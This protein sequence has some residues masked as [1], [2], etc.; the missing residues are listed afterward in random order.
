MPQF[1]P[2]NQIRQEFIDFF[3]QRAR[4]SF[5]PSSA[6]VPHD[7]PTLLFANAGM[8]QFK[9]LFLGNVAPG[10]PLAG[11]KRAVNSQK[12]I[13]AGG[14]HNDL[15][16]VGKDG[17]HHTF[18]EMLGNWSF[19]DYFKEESIQW[20]WEL[21]TQIWG[22][23][24]D[25]LYATYF[26]GSKE[27]GIEPDREAYEIWRKYLPAD[28]ILPGNLKDNFWEMGDTGPCGPCS[29]ITY[30]GRSDAERA[31]V[32]GYQLVNKGD[33]DVIEI[34]NHV[35][36]QFNRTGPGSDGLRQLPSRHVDTGM[37]LE[38]V[39]RF[40]QGK[41]SNYDTD[42]FTP[43]FSAIQRVCKVPPYGGSWTDGK[44]TAY[45][46]IA[47]HIRTLTFA[48]TDGADPG[49]EGR[50]YVLRRILRRAVRFGR[51]TLGV[52]GVFLCE[53]V[54]SVVESMGG[55]FPELRKNPQRVHDVIKDEEEA[56]GR[57]L[58]QGL[59]LFEKAA[60]AGA[61]AGAVAPEDA[62]KLHDTY[63][64]PIDLT[65]LMAD[66]RGLRVDI[67]GFHRLMEEAR[68]RARGAARNTEEGASTLGPEALG[69]LRRMRVDPTDDSDKFHGRKIRASVV[70]IWNG[71]N[72]D[73]HISAS[74]ARPTDQFAVILDR[75]SFYAEM[76]GQVGDKGRLAVS[77]ERRS[78]ARD[79]HDGGEFIVDDT[80]AVGGY[81]L[82]VG[83]ALKGELRVG[84]EVE[85]RVDQVRRTHTASNHTA[86]HLLNWALRETLGDHID[87]KGSLVAPD[88]LRFDFSHPHALTAQEAAAVEQHVAR[89]I[90][91]D[92]PVHAQ[93]VP[94]T[95]ARGV[96]GLRAVFGET[97]PDPVR[98]VSIGATAD[99]MLASPSDQRWRAVSAEFCGGTHLSRTGE[100]KVFALVAE[101]GVAK[102]VRR[103]SALTGD[104][105][106]EANALADRL[107]ARID[108]A[109]TLDAKYLAT[110]V[111]ALA[112]ELEPAALP[113]VRKAELRQR[114]APL[115][116]KVKSA[117]KQAA[118]AEREKAIA[119]ARQMAETATGAVIVMEI[120]A[121]GG[122]REAMLAALDTVR[123]RHARAAIM[124]LS[125]AADG[126]ATVVAA[127]PPEL[128]AS[129]LKAGD[130]VRE[131]SAVMGGKGGGRPDSAQGGGPDGARL[132]D[133]LA[134]AQAFAAA[135]VKA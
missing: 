68:E 29:E 109:A 52:P 79:A 72:F 83:R 30:D 122:D 48:I 124:L 4:H 65:Q 103:I 85:L 63:G 32:P 135:R 53:L 50:N 106:R 35:F 62:F 19:G 126:K 64:F 18:F 55:A 115:Q 7:D 90:E 128:V 102:G 100:A 71:H 43:I 88:R 98:L 8:N 91:R 45:R 70:A 36:I 132:A 58:T 47:D 84:D 121:A 37:G 6:V 116:E 118:G 93:I 54:P 40:I 89:L 108:G 101:E 16:D 5:V 125:R 81:V 96:A 15:D 13:R 60:A 87:Q 123:A 22:M 76:G 129:G 25:R 34:W 67:D 66:E 21:L 112:Q 23:D 73:E 44:D 92:L 51:Q 134:A 17:Y 3:V 56:F 133:A 42:A 69:T 107:R 75:T 99:E 33:P 20:G 105:A 39:T 111:A 114:L 78:S 110:E 86:T 113:L 59:V 38:R 127:V 27:L 12:C 2:I 80:R 61:A 46:V 24:P 74:T 120:A 131:A 26:E 14:K 9:P 49:N 94:L 130:W 95:A 97:Y 77:R 41:A 1:R 28:R 57:T 11:L 104:A 82:H 31:R 117:Q 119:A 10:S